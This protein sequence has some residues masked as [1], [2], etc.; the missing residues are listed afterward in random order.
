MRNNLPTSA[1]AASIIPLL[2]ATSACTWKKTSASSFSD[3]PSLPINDS[4]LDGEWFYTGTSPDSLWT[5]YGS[6]TFNAATKEYI[7]YDG[8]NYT[9][10]PEMRYSL[11]SRGSLSL[12][13]NG[14]TTELYCSCSGHT[15]ST[16][17]KLHRFIQDD[18]ESLEVVGYDTEIIRRPGKWFL[19]GPWEVVE[20]SDKNLSNADISVDVDTS[21]DIF[22]FT[23]D[24]RPITIPFSAGKDLSITFSPQPADASTSDCADTSPAD[25]VLLS[26]LERLLSSVTKYDLSHDSGP[27]SVSISFLDDTGRHIFRIER[28]PTSPTSA[29]AT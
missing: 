26:A 9:S 21:A 15:P 12:H 8:C 25:R 11:S 24:Q 16:Q 29:L 17:G 22:T 23:I 2:I 14:F 5:E 4:I 18:T 7:L 28:L 3:E 6:I 1:G 27:C 20:I 19:K 13:G 10:G